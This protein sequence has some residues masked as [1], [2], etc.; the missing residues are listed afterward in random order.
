LEYYA[1]YSGSVNHWLCTA[2]HGRFDDSLRMAIKVAPFST[3]SH[4]PSSTNNINIEYYL[5]LF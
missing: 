4:S 1:P 3:F 5:E 2:G